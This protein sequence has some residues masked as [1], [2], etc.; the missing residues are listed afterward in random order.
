MRKEYG[1][2]REIEAKFGQVDHDEIRGRLRQLG[3]DCLGAVLET[4]RYFD[5]PGGEL[6]R[7]DRGLR[8]RLA[9]PI[10]PADGGEQAV[11]SVTY[12][13]PRE[14]GLLKIRREIEFHADSGE[15][16][17]EMFTALGLVATMTFQK[18]RES[19][20]LSACLVELDELP[21]IGRFLEVEGPSAE[22]VKAAIE[23]LGLADAPTERNAYSVMLDARRQAEGLPDTALLF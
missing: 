12:K 5:W 16:V 14:S 4:N 8:T 22:E 13:G 18:R 2:G 23:K 17:A 19:W 1:M 11:A 15:T 9:E 7:G 20:R 6:R 10:A 3:A 21:V